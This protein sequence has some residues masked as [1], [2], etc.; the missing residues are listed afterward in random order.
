MHLYSSAKDQIFFFFPPTN[1]KLS[2]ACL[3]AKS[4]PAIKSQQ[5]LDYYLL[6]SKFNAH[7]FRK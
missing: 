1:F 5:S 4:F 7:K 2:E 6:F 3:M